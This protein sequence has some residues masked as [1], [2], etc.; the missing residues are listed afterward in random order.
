M[1]ATCQAK[2]WGPTPML[3]QK[4]I[5]DV[6]KCFLWTPILKLSNSAGAVPAAEFAAKYWYT[7]LLFGV[8]QELSQPP[9]KPHLPHTLHEMSVWLHLPLCTARQSNVVQYQSVSIVIVYTGFC[10][11]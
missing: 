7:F 5:A 4:H 8:V 10:H 6:Q 2:S 9:P 1:Q 3:E 11:G